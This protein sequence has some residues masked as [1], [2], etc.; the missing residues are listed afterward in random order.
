MIEMLIK[1]LSSRFD[2]IKKVISKQSMNNSI[3]FRYFFR[4]NKKIARICELNYCEFNGVICI[5]VV[6]FFWGYTEGVQKYLMRAIFNE[7][8]WRFFKHP[9]A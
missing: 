4:I 3:P 5:C 8:K 9:L 7:E 6:F 1:D 2:R